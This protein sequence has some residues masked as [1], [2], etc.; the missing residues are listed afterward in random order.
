MSAH[1][2]LSQASYTNKLLPVT[3]PLVEF[4]LHQDRRTSALL[5]PKTRSAV[6]LG[7]KRTSLHMQTIRAMKGNIHTLHYLGY[8]Y[9]L[10][11]DAVPDPI[12]NNVID[13]VQL[14]SSRT[15]RFHP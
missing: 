15:V 6:S 1:L 13:L 7:V 12:S 11:L 8:L 9:D 14:L 10:G 4:F 2:Y 3:L 5:S